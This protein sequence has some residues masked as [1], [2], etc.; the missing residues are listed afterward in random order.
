M[1]PLCVFMSV[2]HERKKN[3]S[4]HLVQQ[5]GEWKRATIITYIL[6]FNVMDCAANN[7]R[8]VGM[9]NL[10]LNLLIKIT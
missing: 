10:M 6:G 1:D 2:C 3:V 7:L 4:L 8:S 5:S 9:L